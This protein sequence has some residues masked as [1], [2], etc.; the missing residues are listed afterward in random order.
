MRQI[1]IALAVASAGSSGYAQEQADEVIVVTEAAPQSQVDTAAAVSNLSTDSQLPGLRIDAGELL[2]GIAGVQSDQR[3][4]YAQD[5]RITLRGFGARSAFGVRGVL[6]RLDGIPLSMPD[7]QAQ[8]SSIL[9]DEAENVQVL[10]GPLASIYGNAAGGVIDWRSQAPQ[11][12]QFRVDAM[13]GANSTSRWLLQNDWIGERD[14]IRITGARFQ[15]DGPRAHNS[16]ERNQLALRWYRQLADNIRLIVRADDN[17]AP[18]L[19]DPGSLTPADWRTDPEQTFG[20]ATRFNTRKSIHHQQVS[21]TLLGTGT[22]TQWHVSAWRGWR[23]I[24]QYLPFPGSDLTSSGAVIDLR[25]AFT[26]V[27]AA[28]TTAINDAVKLTIGGAWADQQDR[29]LGYVNDFGTRG[30]VRRDELGTVTNQSLFA[31]AEWQATQTLTLQTGLRYNEVDF[32]V[33]DYFV[34]PDVNPQDSGTLAMQ[35]TSW[36]LGVNYQL[37]DNWSLFIARG[38][39]FETPTL[40]ELAYQND[41]TGINQD[42]GPAKNQQWE[43][44]FKWRLPDLRGQFSAFHIDT[45]DEIVV[46]QSNDGRTTYI[47][48]ERTKRR[49][50]EFQTDWTL[51]DTLDARFSATWLDANY[52]DGNRLPGIAEQQAYGQLNWQPLPH[53]LQLQIA[54]DYR[55]DVVATDD[56][57]VIAPSHVLWHL[58]VQYEHVGQQWS[59]APWLK[60]HNVGDRDYVG[61][62]VVNQGSGRAFEPGVGREL[63]AGVSITRRY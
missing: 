49:G 33:E 12:S 47:N 17:D 19:Q 22:T 1:L 41:A 26:G 2:Q 45:S 61:S 16:A 57:A 51:S 24:E 20:G 37:N 39:G 36:S 53:P 31:L 28:V 3:A 35:A 32:G 46:D 18:L 55:G 38:R 52:S 11:V 25:R 15:T 14:T 59:I 10:R 56:N 40:T 23:D 9:L 60:L 42:L 50:V 13:G 7:G 58:A 54:M 48:A 4:N 5:T 29:R 6:L 63:Q 44:G 43:L 62:V 27:D 30:E 8:T 21:T 34:I